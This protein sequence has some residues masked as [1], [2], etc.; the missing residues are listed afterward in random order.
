MKEIKCDVCGSIGSENNTIFS[1]Y[2][3]SIYKVAL[4]K[5]LGESFDICKGCLECV[6]KAQSET[7]DKAVSIL[8]E[9]AKEGIEKFLQAAYKQ[10]VCVN[11]E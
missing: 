8:V 10:N 2:S 1:F 5:L 7:K 11:K 3:D 6:H 9:R 4:P